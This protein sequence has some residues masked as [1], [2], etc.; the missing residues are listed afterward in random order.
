[1]PRRRN[2]TDASSCFWRS[3]SGGRRSSH[4]KRPAAITLA[5]IRFILDRS[6][7]RLLTHIG[8]KSAALDHEI[9][10]DTVKNRAVEN[11]IG[12]VLAKVFTSYGRFLVEQLGLY[13]AVI[14]LDRDHDFS[15]CFGNGTLFIIV[16]GDAHG[17]RLGGAA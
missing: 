11:A 17:W 1:M 2:S 15:I 4:R 13:V 5:V 6:A 7:R 14:G 9:R 12:N 16:H 10:D 3:R 8:L